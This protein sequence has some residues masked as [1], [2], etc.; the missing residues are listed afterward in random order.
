M[1]KWLLMLLCIPAMCRDTIYITSIVPNAGPITGNTRVLVRGTNLAPHEDFPTPV[2]KFGTKSNI[3]KATYVTCT[4]K[5]RHPSEP[6]PTTPEKTAHCLQCDP[7][8]GWIE[9]DMVPFT[10]SIT[11]DF[12]DVENSVEFQYYLPPKVH[13]IKPIYGT[14]NGGTVV[15]VFGENFIDFDQNLRCSFGVKEVPGIFISD[16]ELYCVAPFS[17]VVTAAMPFRITMNAQQ[18]TTNPI[19][20]WYYPEPAIMKL[21]P[22][23]GPT[24]GGTVVMIEGQDLDPFNDMLSE[25]DNHNDTY[26][27]FGLEFKTPATVISDTLVSC[28]APPSPIIR[29]VPVDLTL[30]DADFSLNPIEWTDDHVPYTYYAPSYVYGVEPNMGPTSGNTTVTIT[31]SNFED[32]GQ[33]KC[34]FGS[35]VVPGKFISVNEIRCVSPAVENPGVVDLSISLV[36]D[37]FGQPVD[38]LYYAIPIIYDIYPKCGP[39]SG[40]TQ[41]TVLGKNFVFTGPGLVRCIFGDDMY[42]HATVMSENEI[43]CDSPSIR[44]NEELEKKIYFPVAVTLN[45]HDRSEAAQAIRFSYY[46]FHKLFSMSPNRGSL[47]GGTRVNIY[48]EHFAQEGVCNVTARFGTTEALSVFHNDTNIQVYTPSGK[49]SGNTIVQVALNGQQFTDYDGTKNLGGSKFDQELGYYYY[50]DPLIT[51]F[52]PKS[53]PATGNSIIV[54]YGTGFIGANETV[55]DLQI[56][57]RFN[58]TKTNNMI[59]ITDCFEVSQNEVKCLTP[60]APPD[61]QAYIELSKNGANYQPIRGIGLTPSDD[62]YDFYLAPIIVDVSP[63]YGPVN[64]ERSENITITGEN[65]RC[66]DSKCPHLT[67]MFGTDPYPIYTPGHLVD[68]K[69]I[70]CPIPQLSRPEVVEVEI[71]LNG[72]DF[73]HNEFTYTYFDAFILDINP[74]FGNKDGGTLVSLLGFGFADTGSELLCRFGSAE[75]PLMCSGKPCVV[76]AVYVSDSEVKCRT[77]ASSVMTYSDTNES[78]GNDSYA[79]E[80]SIRSGKYTHNGILYTP[81]SMPQVNSITTNHGPASGGTYVVANAAFPWGDGTDNTL[82]LAFIQNYENVTIRFS[83]GT[84]EM[85]VFG[86]LI[87]YP[88]GSGLL[89]NSFAFM[90]PEWPYPGAVKISFSINGR[91]YFGSFD[92]TFLEKLEIMKISPACG[93]NHGETAVKITGTGFSEQTNLFIRWGTETR[94]VDVE[95]LFSQTSGSLTAYS[96]PTPTNNTHG[97]FVYVEMGSNIDLQNDLNNSTYSFSGDTTSDKFLYYY[98][99]E[100][101]LKYI[102]PHSGPNNGGTEVMLAGAWFLNYPSMKCTPLCRFGSKIVPGEFISTVRVKCITP[103][104]PGASVTVPVDISFNGVDWTDGSQHFLFMNVPSISYIEP[105]L[106]PS[107]GG[108]MVG[109]YGF[110]FTGLARPQEF[111]CRFRSTTIKLPDKIIPAFFKS[112]NLVYCASPGGWGSGTAATVG[113]TFNGVDFVEG[114][115]TFNFFQIDGVRPRSGPSTGSV[116]GIEVYGSGFVDNP[117]ALCVLDGVESKPLKIEWDRII[118]PMLPSKYGPGF[119]GKVDFEVSANGVDFKK[120]EKGFQFYEQPTV[121]EIEPKSGPSTGNSLLTIYGGPFKNL[122]YGN[123][124]CALSNYISPA[125][126]VDINTITCYTPYIE[127]PRNATGLLVTVSLNGQDYTNNTNYYSVYNL[128]NAAPKGGPI[129]GGTEVL[130]V[131]YGFTDEKPRCRFGT[132]KNNVIVDGTILDDEHMICVSPRDFSIPKGTSLP[133]DIPLEIGFTDNKYSPW[134]AT[135]NKFRFY[136]NPTIVSMSP[137]TGWVDQRYELNITSDYNTRFVPILTG[138]NS[139]GQIDTTHAGVCRFGEYGLVPAVF[140]NR[141]MIKCATPE[142]NLK[143]GDISEQTVLVELAMNGQDFFPVGQY[144]FQGSASGLWVVLLWLLMVIMFA[145]IVVLIGVACYYAWHNLSLPKINW[146]QLGR[147]GISQEAHPAGKPHVF[148]DESGSIRQINSPNR[149]GL[150]FYEEF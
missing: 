17:D 92:F 7:G 56:T 65:F 68:N 43:K 53:G 148:R 110:N 105:T 25:V 39:T 38:F 103:E 9:A 99:K 124:T 119:T 41:I 46:E 48:G 24:T 107:T 8:P 145:L 62:I 60:S 106:G 13:S 28:V 108:T 29:T 84:H 26:C 36:E 140:E 14:K 118:C 74:R 114:N 128:L 33:I 138:I 141:T 95:S 44:G 97:G 104:M 71:S 49:F 55:D 82:D 75:R 40:Y 135:Y 137:A 88:F 87:A 67:C 70:S 19:K 109:V 100:P 123:P 77:F 129:H 34:R 78:I 57:L 94:P 5:P 115:S 91:D 6:E 127:A 144:K 37:S 35:K 23:K 111:L 63:K 85:I 150:D 80:L 1:Q 64:P 61:T 93:P 130:I 117:N 42:T 98:Y 3:V 31:G 73:T 133:L 112:E 20:Y 116:K 72:K 11:G 136:S 139:N 142:T 50:E 125:K 16:T 51:D 66:S 131:G 102:Y 126:I 121:S 30:N 83:D 32:T 10:V 143:R 59:G 4:P 12:T 113:I 146:P 132:E 147:R 15:T 79:I 122:D 86:D 27:R 89:P 45:G 47:K 58:D 81:I 134:T 90:T 18:T 76:Q 54:I 22:N 120:F 21:T 96:A 2:C 69:H 101:V 149:Q 52:R